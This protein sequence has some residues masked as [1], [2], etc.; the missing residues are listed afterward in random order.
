MNANVIVEINNRRD[1]VVILLR[2]ACGFALARQ[3]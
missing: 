2:A 1:T 3:R